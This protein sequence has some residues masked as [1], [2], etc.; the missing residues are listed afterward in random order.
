MSEKRASEVFSFVSGFVQSQ[1]II[2]IIAQIDQ[3]N[4][5][6]RPNSVMLKWELDISKRSDFHLDWYATQ[7]IVILEPVLEM[8][9]VGPDGKVIV[10]TATGQSE[11]KIGTKDRDSANFGDIRNINF[12]G[13]HIYAVGMRRQVYRREGKDRWKILDKGVFQAKI[14]NGI[15]G[16]NAIDGANENSIYAVGFNGEIWRFDG[17]NWHEIESPTNVILNSVRAVNDTRIYA[18][19]QMGTLLKGSGEAWIAIDQSETDDQFWGL[20]W[21]KD[22]LYIA[23]SKQLFI[24]RDDNTLEKVDMGLNYQ[25]TCG[26]LHANDGVL[27]SV[28]RKHV[29]WTKDGKK[30]VDIS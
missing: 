28:G 11:E 20:E 9:A 7:S 12:I 25:P 10:G 19:G 14:E 23:T 8:I 24:L 6:D 29:C 3:L 18:C 5:L 30:W 4:D 15:S 1:N 2:R 13:K 22:D 27:L 16:F 17:K 26:S 21:F